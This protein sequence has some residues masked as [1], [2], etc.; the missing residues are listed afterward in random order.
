MAPIFVDALFTLI[1][2]AINMENIF[3]P[4]KLHL[5]QRLISTSWSHERVSIIYI[6]NSILISISYLYGGFYLC[7]LSLL[8]VCAIMYLLEIKFSQPF[9]INYD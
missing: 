6:L 2:R 8:I 7:L 9:N 4:H 5:F 3:F 1:R